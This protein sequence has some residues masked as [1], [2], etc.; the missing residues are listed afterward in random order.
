M[1]PPNDSSSKKSELELPKER[2]TINMDKLDHEIVMELMGTMGNSKSSVICQIV[3]EWIV[4]NSE[5]MMNVWEIDLAGIKRR[6]K[7][8][9]MGVSLEKDLEDYEKSIIEQF[10]EIF[11]NVEEIS[12]EEVAEVL[13]VNKATI[14][15]IVLSHN[16]KL[17]DLALDL[18]YKNGII[19]NKKFE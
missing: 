5:K 9:A 11:S 15:K 3:K 19:I 12:I 14:R 16:Q 4:Q 13:K 10:P 8:E 2:I 1:T 7:A 18:K 6:V 17:E